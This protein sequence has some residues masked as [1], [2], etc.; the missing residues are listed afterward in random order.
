MKLYKEHGEVSRI[1][2]Q[3]YPQEKCIPGLNMETQTCLYFMRPK[4]S[5]LF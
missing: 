5:I 4:F 2:L 3:A 1:L